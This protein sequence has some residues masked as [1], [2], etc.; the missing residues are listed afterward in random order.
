MLF[1]PR[2]SRPPWAQARNA[3]ARRFDRV[4]T[5]RPIIS[6]QRKSVNHGVHRGAPRT[7]LVRRGLMVRFGAPRVE[8]TLGG[9]AAILCPAPCDVMAPPLWRAR[10]LASVGGPQGQRYRR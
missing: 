2:V 1:P 7:D 10:S 9:A 6:G 5:V 8:N 3:Y 4:T